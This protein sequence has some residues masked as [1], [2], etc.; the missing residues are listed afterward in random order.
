MPYSLNPH[1]P[2]LRAK[3]VDMVHYQGKSIRAVAR[4]FG[5]QPSTVSRWVKKVPQA[6][7]WDIPT[8]SSRPHHHPQD[9]P[10]T[11][12]DRI[13]ELR[14]QTGGRCAEVIHQMLLNEGTHVS[15]STVKRILDRCGMTKKKSKWKKFFRSGKR[16]EAASPGHL[17]EVDTVHLYRHGTNTIYLYTLI[18]VYSR[19]AYVWSSARITS[20]MS[21]RFLQ[22]AQR[23]APFTFQCI[24]SDHGSEFSQHFSQRIHVRHR[25]SRVRKP[26][27]NA[28]V[29]RFNRTIQQELL[30]QVAALDVRKIN[31]SLPRYLRYYNEER[32][33]LG[34]K[35]KTPSQMLI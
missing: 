21:V 28:H 6:G 10:Q 1:L 32:L 35:L 30:P 15:L 9:T 20:W 23:A 8:D 13:K 33:H 3:A 25:H 31:R 12:V 29:E 26:N 19:W 17:I 4:Y 16:P 7:A 14:K 5:V 18:D 34:L 27:D 24:Q 11:I 2:R 22:M